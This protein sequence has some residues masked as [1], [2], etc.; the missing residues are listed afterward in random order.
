MHYVSFFFDFFYHCHSINPPSAST[1]VPKDQY[2]Y[3]NK[4][5]SSSSYKWTLVVLTFCTMFL[6]N[7][8]KFV[9][10]AS[11]SSFLSLKILKLPPI[12][13]LQ[14]W[15]LIVG[16]SFLS[17][18][19]TGIIYYDVLLRTIYNMCNKDAQN[20]HKHWRESVSRAG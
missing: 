1:T 16:T 13:Q 19:Y 15:E 3:M 11:M 17:A 9:E 4:N 5:S 8:T 7:Y 20:D 18:L 6:N 2:V 12:G 10:A 14:A